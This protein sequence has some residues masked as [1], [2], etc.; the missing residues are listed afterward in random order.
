MKWQKLRKKY[1][2]IKFSTFKLSTISKGGEYTESE[3][4]TGCCIY[5]WHSKSPAEI[6]RKQNC[7]SLYQKFGIG[8]LDRSV[9][10]AWE[11][12]PKWEVTSKYFARKENN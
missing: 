12:T 6:M 11:V 7:Y 1:A 10:R 9:A 3:G 8:K 4:H 2:P 5:C